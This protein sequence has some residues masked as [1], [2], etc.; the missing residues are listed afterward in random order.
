MPSTPMTPV[1]L[2]LAGCLAAGWGA[3]LDEA[4]MEVPQLIA[5]HGYPVE[6]HRVV[7]EDGH[8]LV[9]HRIPARSP[10]SRPPVLLQHGILLSSA[11][12][13][14]MGPRRSLGYALSD[15]GYDVWLA[16]ARGNYY[17][18]HH[19]NL[20]ESDASFWDFSWHEMGERD[21]PAVLDHVLARTGAADVLHV[22]HSMGAAMLLAAL[23]S[24]PQYNSKVRAVFALGPA[25]YMRHGRSPVSS[26]LFVSAETY[27]DALLAADVRELLPRQPFWRRLGSVMCSEAAPSPRLLCAAALGL[28]FGSNTPNLNMSRL[29]VNLGHFPAGT[30]RRAAAHFGQAILSGSFRHYDYGAEENAVRYGA[31]EPPRYDLGRV[32]VPVFLYCGERDLVCDCKDVKRLFNEL[33]NAKPK[34]LIKISKYTHMDF[35][36]GIDARKKLFE[37]MI[38][39]MET[40]L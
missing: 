20:T 22:C 7:S 18:K 28:M 25:A 23:H 33:T 34:E 13:V 6:T 11:V 29:P 4:G 27:K 30:S 38:R 10:S 16:N 37:P 15:E 17:S 36:W 12:F 14:D 19:V 32:R 26:L 8:V 31:Q 3:S 1:A 35:L 21:V 24:R 39:K 5:A 40:F 9:L 2:L